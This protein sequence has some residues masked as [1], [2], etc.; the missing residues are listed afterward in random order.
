MPMVKRAIA[1]T[2][3]MIPPTTAGVVDLREVVEG[4]EEREADGKD[5]GADLAGELSKPGLLKR[6]ETNEYCLR[7]KC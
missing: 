2:P 4:E 6:D 1:I 7:E 3:P 5:D